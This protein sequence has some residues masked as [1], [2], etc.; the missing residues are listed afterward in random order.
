MWFLNLIWLSLPIST[1]LSNHIPIAW[2]VHL[3]IKRNHY[4]SQFDDPDPKNPM[5][6][7]LTGGLP[8]LPRPA[9]RCGSHPYW[10]AEPRPWTSRYASGICRW[11]SRGT[12]AWQW[13][14]SK[15]SLW[16]VRLRRRALPPELWG[17]T[18]ECG[19]TNENFWQ[20]NKEY[21]NSGTKQTFFP[22]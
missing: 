13:S 14:A 19:N 9:N 7:F 21:N 4:K 10:R 8:R 15:A 2:S 20:V 11:W 1:C 22:L 6:M 16:E 5:R 12:A 17:R 18:E 3:I